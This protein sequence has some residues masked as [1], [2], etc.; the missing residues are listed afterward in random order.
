MTAPS[1]ASRI[2]SGIASNFAVKG[3]TFVLTLVSTRLMIES[4]GGDRYGVLLL[5]GLLLGYFS[6]VGMGI[7]SGVVKFVAEFRGKSDQAAM[8]RVVSSAFAFYLGIGS[9]IA[10]SI[11]AFALFGL[12]LFR[13]KPE[14]VDTARRILLISGVWAVFAWPIQLYGQVLMGLQEWVEFNKAAAVQA[15]LANL[16]YVGV[17]WFRVPIEWASLA[18]VGTQILMW[19]MNRAQVR[20]AA[21]TLRISLGLASWATIRQVT[22][23]SIWIMI[24]TLAGLLIFQTQSVIAGILLSTGAIAAYAIA[25]TPL[26]TIREINSRVLTTLLPAISEAD[27]AKDHAF[28]AKLVLRGSRVNMA[29]IATLGAIG[30]GTAEVALRAWMGPDYAEYADTARVL[31]LGYCVSA[32]Y[33]V[34]AQAM[35]GVNQVRLVAL[36]ALVAGLMSILAS[37]ALVDRIGLT[38]LAWGNALPSLIFPFIVTRLYLRRLGVEIRPFLLTVLLPNL[39]SIAIIAAAT[40]W[41]S[42]LFLAQR[43][44]GLLASLLFLSVVTTL[45]FA[46]PYFIV[47]QRPDRELVRR[48]FAR[49]LAALR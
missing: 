49:L 28:I 17:A 11:C 3:I 22:N 37:L 46:A 6:L 48:P 34:I 42:T 43:H 47:L 35:I 16:A 41:A 40:W 21:P 2:Y 24:M 44:T 26:N 39:L 30:I 4:Y 31:L 5:S 13:I 20:R 9:V 36:M 18:L 15:V 1:R 12:H 25:S 33:S 32:G 14:D 29:L 10:V 45:A 19:W 23:Y 38:G 8:D 27:G 7:P